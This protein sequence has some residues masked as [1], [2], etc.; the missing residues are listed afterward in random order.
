VA[1]TVSGKTT[2]VFTAAAGDTELRL[3]QN[4]LVIDAVSSQGE[5]IAFRI[6]EGTLVIALS[7]QQPA[8]PGEKAANLGA[9][10]QLEI[11]YHAAPQRGLVFGPELVYSDFFTCHWMPCREEPGD[12]ASFRLELVVP[13]S[14]RVVASGR[15]LESTP[16]APGRTRFVWLEQQPY[17][18]YL[19]GFAAGKLSEA[20]LRSGTSQLRLLGLDVPAAGL[21]Q[22]FAPTPSMVQFFEQKAG[23][24]LPHGSYTQVL[25]PGSA[26]QEKSSFSLIGRDELDPIL[27]DPSEDWVIAHEL[28]HQW[29]GN[30]ITCKDWSHVWLG[31]GL[32][33][34]MVA[35]YKEQRWGAAAY[36][37]EL[38][39]FRQRQT[40]ATEAG[41]D[42][43]LAFAGDYPS[44]RIQRAIVYSKAAL[45]LH[46]LRQE[47][48]D[49]RFW[50]GLRHFTQQ[51]AGQS[52]DSHDFQHDLEAAS[53][54]DLSALFR[55]WVFD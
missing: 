23:V 15:L 14:Y 52:V 37:R 6:D 8:G 21:E 13:E 3:P 9:E 20:T 30:S 28:A 53:G 2:L 24:P 31:E 19:F 4:S 38:A 45:F 40:T 44:L 25:V 7:D 26:A 29:W 22:R 39:L 54:A 42:V 47:L 33:T 32:T 27:S 5:A 48:G 10:R 36:E 16:V 18:S 49:E 41:F 11:R 34:F 12:K 35:A 46:R 1:R 51:R 17:A 43:K 50:K 55:A